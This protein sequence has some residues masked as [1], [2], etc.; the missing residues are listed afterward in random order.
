MR[1]LK[2]EF[3]INLLT[4]V[5]IHIYVY[6]LKVL[7]LMEQYESPP[8]S[9]IYDFFIFSQKSLAN[10]CFLHNIKIYINTF[11]FFYKSYSLHQET[12][13]CENIV[14]HRIREIL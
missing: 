3:F 2:K 8:L 6:K 4:N 7:F 1:I 10:N 11:I 5:Y 9:L 14:P 12:I 13:V